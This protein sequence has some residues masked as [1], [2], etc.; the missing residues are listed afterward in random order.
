MID[1]LRGNGGERCREDR[2]ARS[3]DA[4]QQNLAK[5]KTIEREDTVI[6]GFLF[7]S[8]LFVYNR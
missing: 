6:W 5:G 4:N 7:I 3:G 2:A 1:G 8:L